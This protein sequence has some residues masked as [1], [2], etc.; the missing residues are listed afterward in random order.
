MIERLKSTT[1]IKASNVK[2]QRNDETRGSV[3]KPGMF[4]GRRHKRGRKGLTM[5]MDSQK[6]GTALT[7]SQAEV[8][9]K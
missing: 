7:V 5:K 2:R 6:K 3:I 8:L 9:R 4:G 1:N